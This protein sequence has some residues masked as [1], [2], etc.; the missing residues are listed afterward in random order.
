VALSALFPGSPTLVWS[1]ILPRWHGRLHVNW[2]PSSVARLDSI[3]KDTKEHQASVLGLLV[4]DE[5]SPITNCHTPDG[6]RRQRAGR[7]R[8]VNDFLGGVGVGVRHFVP[9]PLVGLLFVFWYSCVV[10]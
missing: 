7:R 8:L 5:L 10:A 4:L 6:L 2:V 1:D 3:R 9:N